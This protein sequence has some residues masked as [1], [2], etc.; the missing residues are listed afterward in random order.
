[1]ASNLVP[2][3][4]NKIKVLNYIYKWLAIYVHFFLVKYNASVLNRTKDRTIKFF[5]IKH[6][7][8]I[9]TDFQETLAIYVDTS[10]LR[11]ILIVSNLSALSQNQQNVK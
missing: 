8:K 1:M 4:I 3:Y 9:S 11:A 10:H 6:S 5:Y 2:N 7:K